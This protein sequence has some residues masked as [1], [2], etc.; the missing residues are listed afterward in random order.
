MPAATK[1]LGILLTPPGIIVL[2]ALAGLLLQLRWRYLGAGLVWASVLTLLV[3]SL[4]V[5]GH[6]LLGTLEDAATPLRLDDPGLAGRA[7]AIV[8]LGGGR[9]WDAPE[10]ARDTVNAFTLERLR[11]AARLHRAT[12]LPLLLT[13]GAVLGERL[14]EA[15]LMRRA[16][17]QDFQVRARWVEGRARNTYEN[18]LYSRAILA[19]SGVRKAFLVTH[20]WHMPRALWGFQNAGMEVIAAPM[21]FTTISDTPRELLPASRGLGLSSRALHERLGLLWYRLRYRSR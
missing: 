1:A 10:Y 15:E 8:V 21:G 19:R 4:P 11:Y 2:L 7:G 13:G 20:A 17:A 3:L 5:T 18:A 12:G 6:A 16:L 9:E 14:P